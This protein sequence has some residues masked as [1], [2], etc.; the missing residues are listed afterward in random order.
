MNFAL[1]TIGFALKTMNFAFKSVDFVFKMM[2]I[3]GKVLRGPPPNDHGSFSC[4]SIMIFELKTMI[5]N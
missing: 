2:N 5:L 4:V 3:K 1:K